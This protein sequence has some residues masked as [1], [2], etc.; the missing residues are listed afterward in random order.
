MVHFA[1]KFFKSGVIA[2]AVPLVFWIVSTWPGQMNPD[3]TIHWDEG[4]TGTYSNWFPV[5]YSYLVKISQVVGSY[6]PAPLILVQSLT[7]LVAATFLVCS[8]TPKSLFRNLALLLYFA[9]P[10]TGWQAT[11]LNK[12]VLF[13]ASTMCLVALLIRVKRN[14]RYPLWGL[15]LG[16]AAFCVTATR[17]NGP[18]VVLVLIAYYLM[19]RDWSRLYPLGTGLVAGCILL[20]FPPFS[21]NSGGKALRTGGQTMDIAWSLRQD[22]KSFNSNDLKI[23]ENI[24]P[25]S[26]WVESQANCNNSAMP[27]LYDVFTESPGAQYKLDR[28]RYQIQKIWF[29]DLVRNPLTAFT[30]RACKMKGLIVPAKEWWPSYSSP[31]QL[32]F[33]YRY[34]VTSI[35]PI[36]MRFASVARTWLDTWGASRL[37]QIAAMP[38]IWCLLLLGLLRFR[39]IDKEIGVL[40]IIAGFAVIFSVFASGAGLEP[41]YVFPAAS[42]WFVCSLI[43]LFELPS[44]IR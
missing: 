44:K 20:A 16:L 9:W 7:I 25:I 5:V 21:N 39:S 17:W 26:D 1:K 6:S 4:L 12:E 22:L 33:E 19:R 24:A 31:S 23:I 27:L 3:S 43:G 36:S 41:R 2:G 29:K 15:A 13:L 32:V 8:I 37:G 28:S 10:Q 34:S 30:G 42:L 35:A 18:L 38:I 40:V 11:I 14:G